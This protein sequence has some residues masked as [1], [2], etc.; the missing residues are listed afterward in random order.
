MIR[1]DRF[2]QLTRLAGV[3]GLLSAGAISSAFAHPVS[4]AGSTSVMSWNSPMMSDQWVTYSATPRVAVTARYLAFRN[5]AGKKEFYLPQVNFL[6]KRWNEMDSQ[7]NIYLMGSYGLEKKPNTSQAA[8]LGAVE[9]DWESRKYYTALKAQFLDTKSG[10]IFYARARLG[11]APYLGE[12]N[13][14]HTWF[15]L[16]AERQKEFLDSIE[17]TPTLRFFYRNVLWELGASLKGNLAL[18]FMIHF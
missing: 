9:A 16:Q 2:K 12:F 8:A 15:I 10:N 17:I 6:L 1:M 11:V 5:D 13:E 18:N 3:F 14:L 4:F 7:A